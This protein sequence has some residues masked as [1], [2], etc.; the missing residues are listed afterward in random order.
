MI[1]AEEMT[2]AEMIPRGAL[3]IARTVHI[4]TETARVLDERRRHGAA[5]H[6]VRAADIRVAEL[7]GGPDLVRVATPGHT[8]ETV[9][10]E[11]VPDD[12]ETVREASPPDDTETVRL[13][14]SV[15]QD[16][17]TVRLAGGSGPGA[18][19][20]GS[21]APGATAAGSSAPGATAAGGLAPRAMT[22]GS[23]APEALAAG[24]SALTARTERASPVAVDPRVDVQALGRV[25]YEMLTGTEAS[26]GS[27]ILPPT[28][29]NPWVPKGFDAV[30]ATALTGGYPDCAALAA[31]A[32]GA[33]DVPAEGGSPESRRRPI[34][35][36][37]ALALV[38][39]AAVAVGVWATRD[40]SSSAAGPADA[41]VGTSRSPELKKAL[42]GS[43]AFVADAF[44][45]LLP[46]S[47]HGIGYDEIFGCD[48]VDSQFD[49]VSMDETPLG[50]ATVYCAGNTEPLVTLKAS[51][52]VKGATLTPKGD[53]W[54]I[55]GEQRWTRGTETGVL[56]WGNYTTVD[57]RVLGRLEVFFDSPQ[58]KSCYLT[59]NGTGSG[60][61]LRDGWWSR[62]PL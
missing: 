31:A 17:G 57:N 7:P 16:T 38:L 32:A 53:T 61:G 45:R 27:T 21:S 15:P 1:E 60:T 46:A 52:D 50:F 20:A 26:P 44:P 9:R 49:T 23:S 37:I 43:H 48:T 3:D 2:V 22:A 13:S 39:S 8:A 36:A 34:L 51:C 29:V 30:V 42:W 28:Q 24:G 12:T 54:R 55:E 62:A 10:N 11:P 56:R 19:T 25:L 35:L 40:E 6:T 47:I 41:P 4:V 14:G 58:R 18:M 59:I 33:A 5:A